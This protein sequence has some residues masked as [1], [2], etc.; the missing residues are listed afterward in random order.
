[1]SVPVSYIDYGEKFQLDIITLMM[2]SKEF[3]IENREFLDP[4]YFE[5]LPLKAISGMILGFVDK[6]SDLPVEES[7]KIESL[8]LSSKDQENVKRLL[9][10]VGRNNVTNIGFVIDK[11]KEFGKHKIVEKALNTAIVNWKEGNYDA[12]KNVILKATAAGASHDLG[13]FV[14]S[15]AEAR[16]AE[17][18]AG[19]FFV[20][21][22]PTGMKDLD[23]IL[24]GGL[25]VGELGVIMGVPGIGKSMFLINLARGAAIYGKKVAYFTLEMGTIR[26]LTRF[27]SMF[28]SLPKAELKGKGDKI[29]SVVRRIGVTGGEILVKHYPTKSASVEDFRHHIVRL[30]ETRGFKPDL[31]IVDY[32][33]IVKS[34]RVREE[35]RHELT[36]IFDSLRRLGDEMYAAVWTATHAGRQALSKAVVTIGDISEDWGKVKISDVI[37]ALCQTPD[38]KTH[39][40]ARL[41]SAKIRED[42]DQQIIP[43]IMNYDLQQLSFST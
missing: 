38:E 7:L 9:Q 27:D 15:G 4:A 23:R 41:F 25:G 22:I 36:E 35:Y 29:M 28:S 1:M 8:S 34:E 13:E 11:V 24:D 6:Y 20:S 42:K 5:K 18:D 43:C 33:D 3:I 14:I 26:T 37:I 31:I 30:K 16:I 10:D 39:G 12:V 32:A 40:R 19:K 2:N 17:R 21:K